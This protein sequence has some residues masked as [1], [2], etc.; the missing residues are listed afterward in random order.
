MCTL[1][2]LSAAEEAL[3]LIGAQRCAAVERIHRWMTGVGDDPDHDA[4]ELLE[5]PL[6]V[7]RHAA[8]T[9][10]GAAGLVRWY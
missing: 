4:E 3:A 10:Q 1:A 9:G 5:G 6:R 2:Q 7:L 8:S